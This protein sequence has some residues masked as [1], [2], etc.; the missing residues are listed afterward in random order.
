[1]VYIKN[2]IKKI[3]NENINLLSYLPQPKQIIIDNDKKEILRK[4][5]INDIEIIDLGGTDSIANLK[6][7][8]KND[9]EISKGISFNI[10]II[11]DMFYQPHISLTD[12][13]K[14]YGLVEKIYTKF[15]ME[16]G[17]LYSGKGR[18][19]NPIM[20]NIWDKFSKNN[21]FTCLSNNIANICVFKGSENHD[22]LINIF[23][24][25]Y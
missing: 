14:G 18:R 17:N 2:I 10:Q 20:D 7:L 15:I 4:T 6:I 13:L 5:T 1:M 23:N 19:L 11:K 16:F 12:S 24:N 8:I 9:E 3:I 25:M 22:E 21:N